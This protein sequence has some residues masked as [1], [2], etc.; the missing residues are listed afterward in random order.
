MRVISHLERFKFKHL[1]DPTT[2]PLHANEDD[3]TSRPLS[4]DDLAARVRITRND[5]VAAQAELA[6]AEG[7]HERA[8]SDWRA[9][10]DEL[11]REPRGVE[12]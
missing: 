9:A 5:V 7:E 8:I 4:F 3:S 12:P 6:R 1:P 2:Q 10:S 11:T